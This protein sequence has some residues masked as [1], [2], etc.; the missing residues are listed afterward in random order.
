MKDWHCYI[1]NQAYGPY[2]ESLLRELIDRGQLTVD[3]FV[4]NDSPEEAPKGWQRAGDTEIA[5]LLSN[6][7]SNGPT[8][9]PLQQTFVDF[10]KKQIAGLVGSIVLF[11]GVFCP[12]VSMPIIGSVN[13]LGPQ[14]K[15]DG[16]IILVFA[17]ISITVT[18]IKKYKWLWFTG[19]GSLGVMLFTFVNFQMRMSEMKSEMESE[20]AG[21]PFIGLADVAMQSI[22]KLQWGWV[23]LLFG[24][25]LIITAAALKE[26]N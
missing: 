18:L 11:A 17:A 9:P 3:T 12:I 10:S 21:N 5:R 4:Y 6:N 7:P 25:T 8:F 26:E 14:G 19:L 15:G 23:V 24:A 2:T 20:L 16:I 22:I 13:Y 1:N